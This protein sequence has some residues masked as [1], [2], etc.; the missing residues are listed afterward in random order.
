[1]ASDLTLHRY[2]SLMVQR[3]G[4]YR[5]RLFTSDILAIF[6]A[7]IHIGAPGRYL[8]VTD[9]VSSLKA[10]QTRKVARRTHSLVY[11]IKE[12]CWCW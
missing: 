8:I 6:V 11:E 9:S 2:F 7:L 4:G 1:V 12:A 10:L 3:A 5:C